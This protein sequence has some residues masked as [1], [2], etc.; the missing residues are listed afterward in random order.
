ATLSP[1]AQV[2]LLRVLENQEVMRV[3]SPK[4]RP[5]VVRVLSATNEPLD[6]LVKQG[7]FR[8]DLWQRLREAEVHMPPL[9]DRPGEIP[10]LVRHF[11][12]N[13]PGGPYQVSG[14]VMEILCNVSWREGN[15][16][17]LRNCLRAM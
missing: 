4:A 8:A 5:I 11:C 7:T 2:A 17:E 13:M 16:R 1:S 12:A 14:P 10:A 15:I 3:G 9:R 6:Q